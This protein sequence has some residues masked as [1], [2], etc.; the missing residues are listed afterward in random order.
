M[1]IGMPNAR[2]INTRERRR[3]IFSFSSIVRVVQHRHCKNNDG[4]IENSFD[5]KW[6]LFMLI[7][8]IQFIPSSGVSDQFAMSNTT[9]WIHFPPNNN[10]NN[11]STVELGIFELDESSKLKSSNFIALYFTSWCNTT[12]CT[13][14]EWKQA[15]NASKSMNENRT[16]RKKWNS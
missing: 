1:T 11:L 12:K 4:F 16:K 13:R 15:S 10:K 3:I 6:R 9:S 5:I 14:N 8:F 2:R 7:L